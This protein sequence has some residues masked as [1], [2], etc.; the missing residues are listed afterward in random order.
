M[1]FIEIY[2]NSVTKDNRLFN[3][4]L[5]V[6]LAE[7]LLGDL[8]DSKG[9][10]PVYSTNKDRIINSMKLIRNMLHNKEFCHKQILKDNSPSYSYEL[11]QELKETLKGL[12]DL[13]FEPNSS[14]LLVAVNWSD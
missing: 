7:T 2:K 1:G 11:N 5:H 13:T 8:K 9:N 10:K 6:C 14:K 4:K 12:G 3:R